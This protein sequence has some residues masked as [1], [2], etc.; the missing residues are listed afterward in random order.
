MTH[1][2]AWAALAAAAMLPGVSQAQGV[3]ATTAKQVNLRAGPARDYP[4]VAILPPGYPIT[5]QGC[6]QQYTWCDVVAGASRGW[7]YAGNINYYYQGQWVPIPNYAPLIGVAVL[8]FILDDYWSDHYHDRPWYGE[9]QRWAHHPPP[10]P[11]RYRP[12]VPRRNAAAPRRAARAAPPGRPCR[13]A[14]VAST[15]AGGARRPASGRASGAPATRAAPSG[16]GPGAATAQRQ[17][18]QVQRAE[19]GQQRQARRSER[20]VPRDTREDIAIP[21]KPAPGA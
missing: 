10:P 20:N 11:P 8:G 6:L 12:S 16:H 9:R 5:V 13:A 15:R 7:V 21:L 18:R 1:F 4:V 19:Q 2:L 17:Q 3:A 14:A